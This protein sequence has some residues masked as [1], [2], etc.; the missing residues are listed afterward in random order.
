MP[1]SLAGWKPFRRRARNFLRRMNLA[2]KQNSE[3]NKMKKKTDAANA[4]TMLPNEKSSTEKVLGPELEG[5]W[6]EV[7]LD[8]MVEVAEVE[9]ERMDLAPWCDHPQLDYWGGNWSV[10]CATT[11]IQKKLF[12]LSEL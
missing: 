6:E 11:W 3:A 10:Y 9:E 4:K 12:P 1:G 7:I 2:K 5:K 8:E